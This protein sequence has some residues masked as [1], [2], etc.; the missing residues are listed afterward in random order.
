MERYGLMAVIPTLT[1]SMQFQLFIFCKPLVY[2]G[3]F[4]ATT[5]HPGIFRGRAQWADSISPWMNTIASRD[6]YKPLRIGENLV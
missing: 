6:R 4:T 1:H 2:R 3:V 5:I